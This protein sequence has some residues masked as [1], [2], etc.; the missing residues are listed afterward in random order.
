ML[1]AAPGYAGRMNTLSPAAAPVHLTLITGTS[2]GLGAALAT[3]RL[4]EGHQVVGIG[5]RSCPELAALAEARGDRLSQWVIDLADPLPA[6]QT[7]AACLDQLADAPRWASVSLIHNAAL[8]SPPGPLHSTDLQ[9]ASSALRV[10]LESVLLLSAVFLDRTAAW[11]CP[12]KLLNISSGMGR[13]AMAG[14]AV[15]CAAKAG[16]DHLS[17][18]LALEQAALP[19]GARVVSLAPGV[20]DTGMQVQLRGADPSAFPERERFVQLQQQG[21]LDSPA[22]AARKVLAY[23]DREDFGQNPVAD[24]RD[25]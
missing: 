1:P 13:R 10:G 7:F 3:Q 23:L 6:A 15:Y 4:R 8:L 16:M 14:S 20:I 24:V 25:A 9:A 17:R 5:R 21:L 19:D 11:G 22:E 12:R 2:R 18:A